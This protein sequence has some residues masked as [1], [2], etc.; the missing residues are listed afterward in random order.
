[1]PRAPNGADP[2]DVHRFVPTRLLVVDDNADSRELVRLVAEGLGV[3]VVAEVED[4]VTADAAA[5]RHAADVVVMDWQMPLVDGVSATRAIKR[6]RP[7]T[8]VIAHSAAGSP[9]LRDAF[10]RAG[11][12]AFV[13]KGDVAGLAAAL[14]RL[15]RA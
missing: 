1:M 5:A 3:D 15:G 7:G 10:A 13:D 2:V 4:G 12:E 9:E 8:R 11:A 14:T 6:D